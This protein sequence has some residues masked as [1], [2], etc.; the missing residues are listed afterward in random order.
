MSTDTEDD[1][2]QDVLSYYGS[3]VIHVT[4]RFVDENPLGTSEVVLS[5][6]AMRS[7]KK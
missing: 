1:R 2:S 6:V 3:E 7:D 4:A 5:G